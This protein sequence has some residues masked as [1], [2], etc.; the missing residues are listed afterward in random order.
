MNILYHS[1]PPM[2]DTGYGVHTRNLARRL[3]H[4]HHVDIYSVGGWQGMG[5]DWEGIQVYPAGGGKH[6]EQ[7]IPYWYTETDADVVF[8]HHDHW[9]MRDTLR[10][11][12]ENGIPMVLYTI[13]DHDLPGKRAPEVVVQANE[14]AFRTI[15][16]S[17]W[18]EERM[19][20]SR[21]PDEQVSQIPHGVDTAKYAP[22]AGPAHDGSGDL[23]T[24]E[25][26]DD[27][28]IPEDAFLF[29][30]VAANYGPRKHLP[31]HM[32]AFRTFIDK[33]DADDAY[34]YIHAHPTMGG[35][36]NL[37]DIRNALELD[38]ERVMFPDPHK[39][40]H[41]MDD[42]TVVQLYNTFD[43]H[44]N[45]TQSES[46]GLT[47]TEA[48]SCGTPVIATN[49]SALT[50]QFGVPHDT[51]VTEGEGYRVTDQGLLV[52]RGV[53]MW[54]QN[55]SARRWFPKVEDIVNAMAYYYANREEIGRHGRAARE[56][57]VRNYDWD[58]LYETEWLPYFDQVEA[59]LAG[60]EYDEFY[61]QRRAQET[62]SDAFEREAH[63]ILFDIR[64]DAVLDV[65]AGTG[66]LAELL[67]GYG[68]DVVAVE[69]AEAAHEFLDERE[70]E[71]VDD[72]LPKLQFKD[73]SFD[74]A[75]AQHVLEHVEDDAAA[76]SDLAR[77]ARQ[78]TICI[79]PG[80]VPFGG[81]ADPTEFRRYDQEEIERL[82]ADYK[83]LGGPNEADFEELDVSEQ[84]S[85]WKLV[86]D[87]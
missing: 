66:A 87:V 52:H 15:V 31:Q 10:G 17:K 55:A 61:F 70:V 75:V 39:K 82:I 36:Y 25:L 56:F 49:C 72:A 32:E 43:V 65:G 51:Y 30:M 58:H 42:L 24:E 33:Y 67:S 48:M 22:V 41:G 34:F 27:M 74:T 86:I 37:Y 5:I 13:L 28:G 63:A 60:G 59:D 62:Q 26:K 8:S 73:D 47:V 78:R 2:A 40:Y 7:S 21:V 57:V 79:L 71:W 68:Y 20:N 29:G 84:V 23:T 77:V 44:L 6:G 64:G 38:E 35:G 16:M 14:K 45:V 18:A 46:W 81:D 9:A 69:P 85:N 3:K 53:S 54:T 4:D 80:H 50:E 83:A 11:I 76:L 19:H 1:A 12:Q